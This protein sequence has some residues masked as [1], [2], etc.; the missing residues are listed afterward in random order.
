MSVSANPGFIDRAFLKG[1][2]G[3]ENGKAPKTLD[4]EL[5][6]TKVDLLK[7]DVDQAVE[8]TL[9]G[10]KQLFEKGQVRALQKH[11]R[12]DAKDSLDEDA[13]RLIEDL[14]MTATRHWKLDP[15]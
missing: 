8:D 10:A 13:L 11:L 1:G 3:E 9:D 2:L 6:Q 7:I 4:S 14:Q 5:L 15:V 12:A